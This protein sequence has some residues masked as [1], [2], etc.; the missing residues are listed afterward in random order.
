M[1]L[2]ICIIIFVIASLASAEADDRAKER[3]QDLAL[4]K[5]RFELKMN[6]LENIN[7]ELEERCNNKKSS[8]R[9]RFIQQ[10]DLILGEEITEEYFE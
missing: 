10:G 5:K 9:R 7:R 3:E 2:M 1:L 6:K 4:A 8:S